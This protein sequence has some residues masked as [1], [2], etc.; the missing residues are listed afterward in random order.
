M[1]AYLILTGSILVIM[2][3]FIV[4]SGDCRSDSEENED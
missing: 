1:N 4:L 3:I 2:L